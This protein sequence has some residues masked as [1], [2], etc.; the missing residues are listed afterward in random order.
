[1]CPDML[2]K[3]SSRSWRFILPWKLTNLVETKGE[4]RIPLDA[5]K[6]C[7]RQRLTG[8]GAAG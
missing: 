3:S 1:M 8:R 6:V 2:T 7:V 4:H 5:L